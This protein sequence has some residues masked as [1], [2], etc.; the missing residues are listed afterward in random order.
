MHPGGWTLGLG[1][2]DEDAGMREG[3]G[4]RRGSRVPGGG[5]GV[6]A[7]KQVP[8]WGSPAV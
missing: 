8:G 4:D 3:P 1:V 2:G 6:D 7:V 5:A